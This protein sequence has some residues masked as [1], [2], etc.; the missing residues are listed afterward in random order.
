[1]WNLRLLVGILAFFLLSRAI[2]I[3]QS[4]AAAVCAKASNGHRFRV[5]V[6]IA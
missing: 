1:L 4:L 6:A 5:S 2:V 3:R